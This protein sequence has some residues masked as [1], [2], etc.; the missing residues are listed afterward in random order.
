MLAAHREE[1]EKRNPCK[2]LFGQ[3]TGGSAYFIYVH[4]LK[5]QWGT[6]A[7]GPKQ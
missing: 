3:N 7:P 5:E 6:W 1:P 4:S 2:P